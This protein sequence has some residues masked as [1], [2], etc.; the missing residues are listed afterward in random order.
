MGASTCRYRVRRVSVQRRLFGVLFLTAALAV[1]ATF[2][3]AG[4][5]ATPKQPAAKKPVA[6]KPAVRKPTA[7]E[8]IMIEGRKLYREF[9]GHCHALK[10]ARAA[11]FGQ[12]T[13]E[14]GPDFNDVRVTYRRSINA[15]V[16][17]I[18]GHETISTEMTWQELRDVSKYVHF[19]TRKNLLPG[20]T[21][22]G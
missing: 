3:W 20:T 15:I 10:A 11:G 5:S 21:A 18:A 1:P 7:E 9:C 12:P 19:H 13:T 4:E 16:E 2:A 14:P 17:S 6:K 22:Y 8:K